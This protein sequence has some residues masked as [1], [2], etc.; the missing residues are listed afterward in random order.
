MRWPFSQ[1]WTTPGSSISTFLVTSAMRT[2]EISLL[3]SVLV[4]SGA[5]SY[6]LAKT[7][8]CPSGPAACDAAA[9]GESSL[10]VSFGMPTV[11]VA[12]LSGSDVH[13]ANVP[14]ESFGGS[15]S[16]ELPPWEDVSE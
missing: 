6:S 12:A 16:V 11:T 7:T 1:R 4:P 3:C 15:G 9:T 8:S 2:G 10:T 13:F 14:G 5:T